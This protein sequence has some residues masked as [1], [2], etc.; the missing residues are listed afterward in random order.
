MD[1]KKLFF[2]LGL[3]IL[4][5]VETIAQICL[6]DTTQKVPGVFPDS[7][8]GIAP[9]Y[10]NSLYNQVI[11]LVIPVDTQVAINPGGPLADVWIDS[12]IL[13]N[14]IGHPAWLNIDCEPANCSFAGGTSACALFSGTPPLGEA[15]KSYKL[16]YIT[17]SHG[18]L[19]ILPGQPLPAQFDTA[20]DFYTLTVNHPLGTII[21]YQTINIEMY[22]NPVI[23][24]LHLRFGKEESGSIQIFNSNGETV[25]NSQVDNVETYS[26]NM[27]YWQSGIYF[28]KFETP[29]G[30]NNLKFILK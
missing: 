3:L 27:E 30:I 2:G 18:R 29:V 11:T 17:R 4:L 16:S 1:W 23:D 6:P 28:I 7:T 24:R 22:P 19:K 21:P 5:S 15:G 12:I 20:V 13:E 26:I 10:V 14:L 9:A 25:Y 8:A